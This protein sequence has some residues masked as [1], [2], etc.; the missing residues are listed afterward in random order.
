MSKNKL[1]VHKLILCQK[2]DV[3]LM[4]IFSVKMKSMKKY[5]FLCL[6]LGLGG[7]ISVS[8]QSLFIGSGA[9]FWM[10]ANATISLKGDLIIQNATGISGSGTMVLNGTSAQTIDNSSVKDLQNIVLNNPAGVSFAGDIRINGNFNISNT[11]ITFSDNAHLIVGGNINNTGAEIVATNLSLSLIGTGNQLIDSKKLSLINLNFSGSGTKTL[12]DE[13]Q[14]FGTVT[15]SGSSAVLNA[16]GKLILKS[17][18]TATA[19]IAQLPAGV[20]ISG[21]YT[22]ERYIPAIRRFR[23]LASPVVGG[24]AL[25]WRNNGDSAAGLGTH[26]TGAGGNSNGFDPSISN[27][28][29]AFSYTESAGNPTM[30]TDPGWTP[31]ASGNMS[32]LNGEGYRVLV[33]G[34]RTISLT[35]SPAPAATNTTL[36]VS[37]TYPSGVFTKSLSLTGSNGWHLIGNPFPSPISWNAITKNASV[38]GSYSVWNPNSNSYVSYNGSLGDAGDTIQSSQAFFVR[39]IGSGA[40][41]SIEEA[42]KISGKGG[43]FGKA[44][45]TNHLKLTLMYDSSNYDVAFL[46]FRADAENGIDRWDAAKMNNPNVNISFLSSDM[47]R[48]SIASYG[49]MESDE[50]IVPLSTARS[51]PSAL[52]KIQIDGANS[53]EFYKPYLQDKVKGTLTAITEE[54]TQAISLAD[55][56]LL[57]E[58][59]LAIV[60]K[61]TAN[62]TGSIADQASFFMYPNPASETIQLAFDGKYIH[63]DKL[64]EIIDIN[65]KKVLSTFVSKGASLVPIFIFDLASGVYHI[66]ITTNTKV[67]HDKFIKQ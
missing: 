31:F 12:D 65:G 46:H 45:L 53:F 13:V 49:V 54:Y 15:G 59:R 27:N 28:P 34:D 37:G 18:A 43:F 1:I 39:A 3:S 47:L 32:L 23:F 33:R 14:V 25:Q 38:S 29:S 50:I 36:S 20:G 30:T 5:I 40:S 67:T 56:T 51:T 62:A 64:V 6:L 7:L 8:A 41:I 55:S 19:R 35:T 24:T 61:K 52:Y 2:L 17:N 42:D 26:I 66:I 9:D 57:A 48:Q 21:T 10:D 58:G 44:Q 22:V 16:N 11:N 63:E 4:S 60:F